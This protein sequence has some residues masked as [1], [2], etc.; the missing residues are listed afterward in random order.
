M[1]LRQTLIETR[2]TLA[3]PALW[4]GLGGLTLLQAVFV[5]VLHAQMKNGYTLAK[6]GLEADLISALAFYSWI[7]SLVYAISAAVIAA[8]DYPDRSIQLWLV[9]GQ[10]R[11]VLMLSRLA[12]V[13]VF[14]LLLAAYTVLV[15][16]GIA[17]LSR[18]L[19]FGGVDAAL[20]NWAGLAPAVLRVFWTSLPYLALTVLI[21]TLTRSP[22]YAAAG[23]VVYATVAEA[24]LSSLADR[25]PLLVRYLPAQLARPLQ[26]NLV[27]LS[28]AATPAQTAMPETQAAVLIG[29]LALALAGAALLIFTRQDLGG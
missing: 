4:L 16:L 26:E 10:P 21:A 20:L 27:S 29:L 12:L 17:A 22:M 8:Y 25:F 14:G 13:L 23:T 24:L 28:L 18:M 1:F 15:S 19:F 11:V 7:G 9:R 6:G 3:H 2:K 5:L